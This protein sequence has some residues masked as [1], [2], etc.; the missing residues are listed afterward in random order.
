MV[1]PYRPDPASIPMTGYYFRFD[2][3]TYLDIGHCFIALN[4]AL[5]DARIRCGCTIHFWTGPDISLE[6]RFW[7]DRILANRQVH[8]ERSNESSFWHVTQI[9]ER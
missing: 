6:R 8:R 9:L 3:S 4:P 1:T 5:L 7:V 2:Y